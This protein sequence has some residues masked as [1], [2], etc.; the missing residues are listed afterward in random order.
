MPTLSSKS[1]LLQFLSLM[2]DHLPKEDKF[3]E[4]LILK[5]VLWLRWPPNGCS[6]T[7][8]KPA[9]SSTDW[10]LRFHTLIRDNNINFV[11]IKIIIG[12][13]WGFTFSTKI[14]NANFVFKIKIKILIVKGVGEGELGCWR[15]QF[16]WETALGKP[17][18][19]DQW[20][21][22]SLISLSS[23]IIVKCL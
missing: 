23:I 12:R 15:D 18:P 2:L 1:K 17:Q 9:A 5:S 6:S 7:G 3:E 4:K 11:L 8:L 13:C 21:S 19:G 22:S 16:C 14:L 20:S 10:L